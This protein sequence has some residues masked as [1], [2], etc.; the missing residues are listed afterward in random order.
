[1][2][3]SRTIAAVNREIRPTRTLLV[4]EERRTVR[5]IQGRGTARRQAIAESWGRR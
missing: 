1:M 2:Y 3:A 4:G 5:V